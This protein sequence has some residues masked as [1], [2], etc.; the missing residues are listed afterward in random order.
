MVHAG[1]MFALPSSHKRILFVSVKYDIFAF[2]RSEFV[3]ISG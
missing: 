1:F 2:T 3:L